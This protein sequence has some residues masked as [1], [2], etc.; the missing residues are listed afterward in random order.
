MTHKCSLDIMDIRQKLKSGRFATKV[1][2]LGSILLEDTQTCEAIQLMQLPEGY[3]FH[4]KGKWLPTYRYT[5]RSIDYPMEGHE[6]W[7]CSVCGCASDERHDWCT[8]GA[9]MREDNIRRNIT[10][11]HL[12]AILEQL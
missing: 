1:N 9:D 11:R 4:E 3:S 7:E 12:E 6:A 5:S 10:K 2:S 8:C